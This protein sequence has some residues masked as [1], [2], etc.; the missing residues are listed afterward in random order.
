MALKVV[1]EN[2]E[3]ILAY[4]PVLITALS[5]SQLY[6]SGLSAILNLCRDYP[7]AQNSAVSL[8]LLAEVL[9]NVMNS[10][11]LERNEI[12]V[13]IDIF[14]LLLPAW[15]TAHKPIDPELPSGAISQTIAAPDIQ[16]SQDDFLTCVDLLV[17]ILQ[18]DVI[19]ESL[20]KKPYRHQTMDLMENAKYR[21]YGRAR[22]PNQ[23]SEDVEVVESA[24]ESDDESD[25]NPQEELAALS[26][27]LGSTI[28]IASSAAAF[29]T[30]DPSTVSTDDEIADLMT[31]LTKFWRDPHFNHP[32]NENYCPESLT[33]SLM[34]GN[35]IRSDETAD[36]FARHDDLLSS[37]IAIVME[38]SGAELKDAAAGLLSNLAVS[39]GNKDLMRECG[40]F[41]AANFLLAKDVQSEGMLVL[42]GVKLLR[43]LLRDSINNAIF[44][45]NGGSVQNAADS[46]KTTYQ[47]FA[48]QLQS[49]QQTAASLETGADQVT[50]KL[51]TE[52]TLTIV[53][54]LRT[55]SATDDLHIIPAVVSLLTSPA[56]P[57]L[58]D[59]L[60]NHPDPS[61]K[62]KTFL[63]LGLLAKYP[64]AAQHLWEVEILHNQKS[65]LHRLLF[66]EAQAG[67]PFDEDE[68][69]AKENK[70]NLGM[71]IGYILK[72]EVSCNILS[73]LQWSPES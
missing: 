29:W 44:F 18:E 13:A 31:W 53:D 33:A 20:A 21:Y 63:G 52:L 39:K 47:L 49:K 25:D 72:A 5:Q 60:I 32:F 54:L 50:A 30:I 4:L 17:P 45:L 68:L 41:E 61:T 7:P 64:V 69:F 59:S 14:G 15:L 70:Q 19:L 57:Q 11:D 36:A 28:L 23:A 24:S 9:T 34:L 38:A 43:R 37:A 56:V 46:V 2:R 51:E 48:D 3:I 65:T 1:D 35:L 42:D 67:R 66:D 27:V 12:H 55:V 8:D 58:L 62:S 40:A 26:K 22:L 10:K 6:L 16:H 71:M 73:V